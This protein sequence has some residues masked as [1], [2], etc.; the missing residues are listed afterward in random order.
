MS[1][2]LLGSELLICN[3]KSCFK[4]MNILEPG[5]VY[6]WRHSTMGRFQG[7]HIALL[8]IQRPSSLVWADFQWPL[9]CLTQNGPPARDFRNLYRAKKNPC[10]GWGTRFWVRYLSTSLSRCRVGDGWL[11]ADWVISKQGMTLHSPLDV[12]S[13]WYPEFKPNKVKWLSRV[14][15]PSAVINSHGVWD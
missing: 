9:L 14:T 12:S 8:V 1:S 5:W 6:V 11:C 7:H 10:L 13:W 2:P 15:Q 3:Q 4:S